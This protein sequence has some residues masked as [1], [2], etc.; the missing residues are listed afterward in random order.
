[1]DIAD[2]DIFGNLEPAFI[3]HV[4]VIRADDVSLIYFD[5]LFYLQF[6]L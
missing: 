2:Q 6:V 4:D 1:M 5:Y 3:L